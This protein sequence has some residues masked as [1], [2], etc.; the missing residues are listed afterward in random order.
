MVVRETLSS[1]ANDAR[2]ARRRGVELTF[3]EATAHPRLRL[4]GF[5]SYFLMETIVISIRFADGL[6]EMTSDAH[7]AHMGHEWH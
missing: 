7:T 6:G 4:Q 3:G 1:A 5:D 2:V